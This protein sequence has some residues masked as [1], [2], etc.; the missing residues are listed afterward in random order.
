MTGTE[1]RLILD[2]KPVARGPLA[3]ARPARPNIAVVYATGFGEVACFDGRPLRRGQQLMSKWRFRYDVD[4]SDH[5]RTARLERTPLPSREDAYRF[6]AEVDVGFRVSDPEAIVRRN[7]GDALPIVYGY[8]AA[9]F[10]LVTR[11]YDIRRAEDA[12][13]EINGWCAR[14][15]DLPEGI[16][17]YYCSVRLAPDSA[18][19]IYLQELEEV[20]RAKTVGAAR[21]GQDL[22]TAHHQHVMALMAEQSRQELDQLTARMQGE[23]DARDIT[24]AKHEAEIVHITSAARREEDRLEREALSNLPQDLWGMLTLHLQRHPDETMYVTELYARH[25]DA[26]SARQDVNDQ[27]SLELV[28]YMMDRDLLQ[29]VDIAPLRDRAMGRVHQIA[30]PNSAA[31]ADAA[32]PSGGDGWDDQ[33]PDGVSQVIRGSSVPGPP[34]GSPASTGRAVPVYVL[35]DESVELPGYLDA[36]NAGLAGLPAAL[37]RDADAVGAIR[38]A[39]LGYAAEPAVRIP[40]TGVTAGGPVPALT[41]R[42]GCRL[43]PTLTD[44]RERLTADIERCKDHGLVVAR[45]VLVVLSAAPPQDPADWPAAH[46][47]LTDRATFR[48]APNIVACG[49]GRADPATIARLATQP[50]Q[51]F[52]A[53]AGMPTE[54]SVRSFTD[55][56]ARFVAHWAAESLTGAGRAVLDRPAGFVPAVAVPGQPGTAAQNAYPQNP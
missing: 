1:V 14:P 20:E 39:L 16:T 3:A 53:A 5:R 22:G 8:L 46:H 15:A 49:V 44:L 2:T 4:L 27:R 24:R 43:A 11:K 28:R 19:R 21:H 42:G 52:L 45:P 40:L 37:A 50:G 26:V 33:L 10:R 34:P 56:L 7:V 29:P 23:L 25:M 6:D 48:Y 41:P 35:V 55:F 51:A 12:E 30:A 18:A 31:A 13:R 36:V 38:L 54:Y 17:I 9:Q 32:G 47:A